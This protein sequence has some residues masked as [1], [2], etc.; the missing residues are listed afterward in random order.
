MLYRVSDWYPSFGSYG[1]PTMFVRLRQSEIAALVA[2]ERDSAAARAVIARIH[3]AVRELP[4]SGFIHADACSPTDAPLV[5]QGRAAIR[6]GRKGWEIITSSDK[7]RT[8]FAEG[9]TER[10]GVHPY[11][12][13]D[14]VREFRMFVRNRSVAAM[15]QMCLTR[16]FA[17]LAGR[18]DEIWRKGVKLFEEIADL[19]PDDHLVIDVYLTSAGHLMIIDLNVWGDPTDPLLLR[20]WDRDWSGEIGLKL[21]PKPTRLGGDVEVS[22]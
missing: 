9:H 10:L 18:A 15:S 17:R 5:Q 3:R 12:R 8:A 4:G 2:C 21:I 20:R 14:P 6:S 1:F 13:M 7:V 16:H 19:I 22:F 11:R